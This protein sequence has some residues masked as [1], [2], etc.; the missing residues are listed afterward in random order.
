MS[1]FEKVNSAYKKRILSFTCYTVYNDA[2]MILEYCQKLGYRNYII[3]NNYPELPQAVAKLGLAEFFSGYMISADIGFE[4]PRPEIFRQAI[5]MAGNPEVCYMVGDNPVAD[6]RG[7]KEN[8]MKTILVHS[9]KGPSE[10]AD[11]HCE[12]L[13]EIVEI[14]K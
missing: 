11:H 8:G 6:I 9:T 14:L 13:A 12:R 3:S 7:A 4:K 1:E 2:A 5:A 10:Y